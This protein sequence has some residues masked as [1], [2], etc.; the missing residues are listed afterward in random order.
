MCSQHAF[1]PSGVHSLAAG[2]LTL[3]DR[4]VA[5]PMR[6][7]VAELPMALYLDKVSQRADTKFGEV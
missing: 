2:R 7:G 5:F 3:A 4:Q 1:I 6:E